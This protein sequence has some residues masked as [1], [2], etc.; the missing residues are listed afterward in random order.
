MPCLPCASRGPKP[1]NILILFNSYN[2]P[3]LQSLFYE[4]ENRNTKRISNVS[5]VTQL[6][7]WDPNP[8]SV[9]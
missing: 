2:N 5:K 4:R 8:G 9:L 1:V 3:V 7:S 6:V